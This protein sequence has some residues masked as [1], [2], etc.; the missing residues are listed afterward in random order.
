[1]GSRGSAPLPRQVTAT[2][3]QPSSLHYV[4]IHRLVYDEERAW[5]EENIDEVAMKHFPGIDRPTALNR[6]ILFSNWMTKD[7]L[8]VEREELECL[9]DSPHPSCHLTWTVN[10]VRLHVHSEPCLQNNNM[11]Q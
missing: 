4:P 3:F 5:T 8:P 11:T 7:Y 2:V 1:M 9:V 10:I 6:P